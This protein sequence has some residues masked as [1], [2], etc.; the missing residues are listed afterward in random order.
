MF[1]KACEYG[2]RAMLFIATKSITNE[3]ARLKEIAAQVEAP[4]AFTAKVLQSLVR[5]G[6]LHSST[7]PGGGFY[8]EQEELEDMKLIHIV[9]AI[10]G[11]DVFTRCGLGLRQCNA[12]HPCPAHHQFY[13][14]KVELQK[15]LNSLS[16]REMAMSVEK[17]NSFLKY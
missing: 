14:I 11:N 16:V 17:Q 6:I 5:M 9:E 4:E 3:K 12:E 13:P 15:M 10:D 8:L 2:I 1:S 7:G